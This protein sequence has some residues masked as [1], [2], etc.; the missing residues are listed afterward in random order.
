VREKRGDMRETKEAKSNV[1][2]RTK[3]GSTRLIVWWCSLAR[4]AGN[5]SGGEGNV[6]ARHPMSGDPNPAARGSR[7]R[8]IVRE[9]AR[10]A[11]ELAK[12]FC[13]FF[14]VVFTVTLS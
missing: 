13:F 10:E 1:E 5:M 6:C 4:N 8:G 3:Q 9:A 11:S 14:L 2:G 12:F 7:S